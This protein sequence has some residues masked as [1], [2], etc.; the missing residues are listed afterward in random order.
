MPSDRKQ[1]NVRVDEQTEA[2][3]K[4]LLPAVSADIG[5][6]LTQSD[7]F[8]LGLLELRKKYLPD[9]QQRAAPEDGPGASAKKGKAKK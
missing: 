3:L 8:R 1:I 2:L 4:A 6:E 7:L 5:L 9:Y